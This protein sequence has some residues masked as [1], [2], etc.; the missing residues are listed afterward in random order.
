[1]LRQSLLLMSYFWLI[2]WLSLEMLM[3]AVLSMPLRQLLILMLYF[4]TTVW[5][6]LEMLMLAPMLR[7]LLILML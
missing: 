7:E 5:L 1:M 6:S 4:W 2:V 3:L